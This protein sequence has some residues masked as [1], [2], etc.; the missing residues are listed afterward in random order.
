MNTHS[1][2]I[3]EY[4][5][6]ET[7]HKVALVGNRHYGS[8]AYVEEIRNRLLGYQATGAAIHYESITKPSDLEVAQFTRVQNFRYESL[9]KLLRM[10]GKIHSKT[11]LTSVAT[12]I[13]KESWEH[14]DATMSELVE[15]ATI[16][17]TLALGAIGL[18]AHVLEMANSDA[19]YAK[20]ADAAYPDADEGGGQ[21]T[22]RT[23]G[24]LM[25]TL[26]PL[27]VDYRNEVALGAV[28]TAATEDTSRQIALLWGNGHIPGLAKGLKMRGYVQSSSELLD[29]RM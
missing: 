29:P 24:I 12:I 15:H 16:R 17:Q 22:N 27:I 4:T 23:S 21:K 7:D 11:D 19:E 10:S 14:H 8:E 26:T 6:S 18:A 28:D 1:T 20:A 13:D 9:K 2:T 3:A 5:H 25:N